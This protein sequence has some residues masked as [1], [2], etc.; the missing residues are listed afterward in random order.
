MVSNTVSS[1]SNVIVGSTSNVGSHRN[2][3]ACAEEAPGAARNATVVR[4][5]VVYVF[6]GSQRVGLASWPGAVRTPD[7]SSWAD[8]A[9]RDLLVGQIPRRDLRLRT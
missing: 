4:R 5:T 6:I 2:W 1:F 8:A 7:A 3:Q 9:P